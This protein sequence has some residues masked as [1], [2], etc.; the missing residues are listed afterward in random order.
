[1][2]GSERR[3]REESK[4]ESNVPFASYMYKHSTN[5]KWDQHH[6]TQA[7]LAV[8]PCCTYITMGS[9]LGWFAVY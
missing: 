1:M 9:L 7:S 6:H 8:I 3:G 4:D 2:M 5:I